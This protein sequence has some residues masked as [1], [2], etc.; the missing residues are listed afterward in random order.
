MKHRQDRLQGPEQRSIYCQY[1]E[2]EVVPKALLLLVH[3]AGE[4]S[5]RYLHLAAFFTEHDIA[6]A[7][8]DHNGHGQSSGTPGH[9]GSFDV[10]LEDLEQFYNHIAQQFAGVPLFLLGHSLGGLI[11]CHYLLQRQDSFVGCVLSGPLIMSELQPGWVQMMAIRLLARVSP[12]LGLKQLDASGVS[13]DPEQ[14]KKYVAD[15]LVFHGKASARMVGELFASMAAMQARVASIKLPI[16]IL[17]GGADVM[18][19]P[20]GSRYLYEHIRSKDK[21]L[22][23]YP[24]LYHEI[25]NEPEQLDVLAQTLGWCEARLPPC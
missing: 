4:H 22:K 20:D 11:S 15:P 16:L 7:A 12:Q 9:V 25:F 17:H 8:L 21:T 23:I 10:Y 13:R 19:S 18:T 6:V 3:G 2:P 24:G 14:V 5:G 1:W